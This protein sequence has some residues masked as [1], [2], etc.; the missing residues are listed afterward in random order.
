MF[1]DLYVLSDV[2]MYISVIIDIGLQ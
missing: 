2:Y 1:Y